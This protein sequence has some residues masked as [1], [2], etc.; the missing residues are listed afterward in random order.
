MGKK[1]TLKLDLPIEVIEFIGE[2]AKRAGV[3]F[4]D[5]ICV[6][7]V[8]QIQRLEALH[9]TVSQKEGKKK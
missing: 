7:L 4:D 9:G 5:V 3:K 8:L 1:V 2:T 6:I